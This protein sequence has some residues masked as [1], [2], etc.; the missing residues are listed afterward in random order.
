[1]TER[2]RWIEH[3]GKRIIYNDF[4]KI[5]SDEVVR[6]VRQ[7]EQLV[8]DSKDTDD[9]IVLSNMTDAHFFG[10]AFEEI[11]RVTKVVRPYIKKRAVV[12][13][14]GVKSILYKSVNMFARGTPTKMFN[15]IEKAKDY[16]VE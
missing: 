8:M 4:S 5:H 16:L 3:K 2:V 1:M 10:E 7:F 9:I 13:I 14:S 15:T 12:G 11:K 6:V